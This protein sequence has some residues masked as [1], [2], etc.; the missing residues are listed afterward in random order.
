VLVW[1]TGAGRAHRLCERSSHLVTSSLHRPGNYPRTHAPTRPR[2]LARSRPRP[3]RLP[4][5]PP[6]T[7]DGCEADDTRA[8]LHC[9]ERK[10]AVNGLHGVP[11]VSHTTRRYNSLLPCSG[12]S[13]LVAHRSSSRKT[14]MTSA[15]AVCGVIPLALRSS[16]SDTTWVGKSAASCRC[17]RCCWLCRC[18]GPGPSPPSAAC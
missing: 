3:V 16:S 10:H 5:S 8:Q 14:A 12:A 11:R 9:R 7:A 18:R 4:N 6:R 17:P 2:V 15:G 1:R 13:P